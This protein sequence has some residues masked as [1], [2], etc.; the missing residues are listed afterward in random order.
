M[1]GVWLLIAVLASGSSGQEPI[2]T[3]KRKPASDKP[4]K[5][6]KRSVEPRGRVVERDQVRHRKT[7]L[8]TRREYRH[9]RVLDRS[10][11]SDE[12]PDRRAVIVRSARVTP[13]AWARLDD[14]QQTRIGRIIRDFRADQ[15]SQALQSW[16]VFLE[17]LREC[18]EPVELDD[19]MLYIAR[20]SCLHQDGAVLYYAR[21]L[22]Y[23]SDAEERL[24]DFIDQLYDLR[25][26]C[27]RGTRQCRR[28]AIGRIEDELI[29]ARA[30]RQ[31]LSIEARDARADFDA[32]MTS[33]RHYEANF[34]AVWDSL[35]RE[36]EVRIRL[37]P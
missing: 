26:D 29:K 6:E 7:Y 21:K 18:E 3:K 19:V 11:R 36:V 9:V 13:R 2:R 24:D 8:K 23:L 10:R 30:E 37:R 17:D 16:S 33:D 35:Y 25:E 32:T 28:D 34:T 5:V 22:E 14:R 27:R 20:E 4:D 1:Y 15:R 12:R 31:I